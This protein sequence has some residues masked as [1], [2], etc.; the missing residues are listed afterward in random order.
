ML[1]YPCYYN[2][3]SLSRVSLAVSSASASQAA[4]VLVV[5]VG[6]C[7]TTRVI[8]RARTKAAESCFSFC[9][10]LHRPPSG[11][12]M[13]DA[14]LKAMAAKYIHNERFSDV[15]RT[16]L[17]TEAATAVLQLWAVSSAD[18]SQR[19]FLGTSIAYYNKAGAPLLLTAKHVVDGVQ[20]GEVLCWAHGDKP[21][22]WEAN[23]VGHLDTADLAVVQSL[24]PLHHALPK[25][26]ATTGSS[27]LIL[28]YDAIAQE[29][30][31]SE[32]LISMASPYYTVAAHSD[33]GYSGGPILSHS[34]HVLGMVVSDYGTTVK[35]TRFFS[36]S[37]IMLA[38][39]MLHQPQPL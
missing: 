34:G 30:R 4:G 29:L 28:G 2:T 7:V 10:R 37:Q 5:T 32:G 16:A 17:L 36:T 20:P 15:A 27:G 24:R 8:V 26:D 31:V 38:L 19:R 1:A 11:T 33:S 39:H 3:G 6:L 21:H 9:P 35:T 14:I 23:V 12:N 25:A 13:E 18:S 22:M